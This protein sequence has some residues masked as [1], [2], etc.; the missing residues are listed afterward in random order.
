[1]SYNIIFITNTCF[2]IL[3]EKQINIAEIF[4]CRIIPSDDNGNTA[5]LFKMY[6]YIWLDSTVNFKKLRFFS[7]L[8]FLE[9]V[10]EYS[11]SVV[12]VFYN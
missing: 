6:F 10:T 5:L 12:Q 7:T 2:L 9:S 1:M 11:G 4:T 3:D 8:L